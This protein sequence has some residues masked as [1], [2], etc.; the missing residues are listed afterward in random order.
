MKA[1]CP[2]GL[3]DLDLTTSLTTV[4][5]EHF[6][7]INWSAHEFLRARLP[8]KF[9]AARLHIPKNIPVIYMERI[10]F[11]PE[12]KPVEFLQSVWR[13]DEYDYEFSLTRSNG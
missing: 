5:E 12:G 9:E 1:P 13:S 4:M 2:P 6:G 8:T 10:T 7:V 11:S 3:I